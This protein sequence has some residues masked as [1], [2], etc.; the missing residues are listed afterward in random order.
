MACAVR[1]TALWSIIGLYF[2]P[3]FGPLRAAQETARC[4]RHLRA[5]PRIN[6]APWYIS[7][8]MLPLSEWHTLLAVQAGAAATLTG[9][10][11]VAISIN[12]AK[13]TETP[14]LSGR[15]G[16]SILQFL[17]VFFICTVTL[18]PRQQAAAIAF[19]IL[20]IA[21][22][23]WVVQVVGQVRYGKS[24]SGHP[25]LWL[26]VRI[27]QTQLAS[28]PFFVAGTYLLSGSPIG[29]YWLVPGFVFSFLAGVA[30]AWVLLVE[31][32]R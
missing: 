27:V 14:G 23:S 30:S 28:I 6:P 21:L 19:E 2:D 1:Q 16:D 12:L 10:V 32:V 26:I 5:F 25:L 24:R 29:F 3:M 4:G 13:I 7:S 9:L 31:I 22:F 17:Q 15:A 20:A 8:H 11:F 18:I